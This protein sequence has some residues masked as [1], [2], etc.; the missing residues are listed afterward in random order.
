MLDAIENK[1][2]INKP[3]QFAILCYVIEKSYELRLDNE[4]QQIQVNARQN[5]IKISG[6]VKSLRQHP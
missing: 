4:T 5:S 2:D 1:I 3:H 6:S